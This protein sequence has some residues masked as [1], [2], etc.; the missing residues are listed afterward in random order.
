MVGGFG[1]GQHLDLGERGLTAA[2]VVER[3][4][5][6]QAMGALLHRERA[7][8]EWGVHGEG[9]GFDAGFFGVRGVEHLDGI[10]VLLGPPDVHPHQ[11]LGPV[12]G[13][14]AAR[15]GADTD[16]CL[17]L[18]VFAGQQCAHLHRGDVLTQLRPLGV[19]LG[20]FVRAAFLGRE[21]VEHRQVLETSTQVLDAAELVLRVGQ[22]A[23]D[24]LPAGLVVPQ[25]GVG[26][27][28]FEFLDATA[29]TLDVEHTL[30]GGERGVEG[31]D[32]GL[33]VWIHG[34]SAYSL[35]QPAPPPLP[36]RRRAGFSVTAVNSVGCDLASELN[37]VR[38]RRDS[39]LRR[40]RAATEGSP[41]ALT[42]PLSCG[43]RRLRTLGLFRRGVPAEVR[44]G[45][46]VRA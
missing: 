41:N 36:A 29:K 11:H 34:N 15:A 39:P 3:A 22:L 25:A 14:D 44:L 7:V 12:G 19:G 21:L 28:V 42:A 45:A 16:Q 4:D 24:A 35:M 46:R 10:V 6:H 33:A 17:A 43:D 20:E 27:F 18:V 13:V 38:Q 9:G 32:V 30:H 31:S 5:P 37:H 40:G 1:D 2:L 8:G 23:G 26:R